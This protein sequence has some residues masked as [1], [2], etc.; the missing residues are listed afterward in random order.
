MKT[1][2]ILVTV[3]GKEEPFRKEVELSKES[4]RD[5]IHS[6]LEELYLYSNNFEHFT[7]VKIVVEE[8]VDA[9]DEEGR[10]LQYQEK[11][12]TSYS[13]SDEN[14]FDD[15]KSWVLSSKKLKI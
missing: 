5:H 4:P 7:D 12:S 3:Y 14:S 11:V 9:E 8:W 2:S 10:K 1:F 6:A 15:F 13:W